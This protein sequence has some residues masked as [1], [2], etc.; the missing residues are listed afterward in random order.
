MGRLWPRSGGGGRRSSRRRRKFWSLALC[1]S[2]E[3]PA[4]ESLR[5]QSPLERLAF[6]P[7]SIRVFPD[8]N[9]SLAQEQVDKP[10]LKRREGST[11]TPRRRRHHLK[12]STSPLNSPFLHHSYIGAFDLKKRGGLASAS[13]ARRNDVQT[14]ENHSW[15]ATG[16]RGTRCHRAR[17]RAVFW[18][19]VRLR[20]AR[21]FRAM[22][23]RRRRR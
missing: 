22:Q 1:V 14:P 19:R 10:H 8:T 2:K 17:E 18:P 4:V 9:L 20:A 7:A 13:R 23:R 5:R 16:R 11:L 3:D 15:H 21:P 6:G 12:R